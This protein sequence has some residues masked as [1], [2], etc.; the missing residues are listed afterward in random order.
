MTQGNHINHALAFVLHLVEDVQLLSFS[1]R[2][3]YGFARMPDWMRTLI[4]GQA[5]P[6][7][8]LNLFIH[9][10][11]RVQSPQRKTLRRTRLHHTVLL[12]VRAG[13]TYGDFDWSG[14]I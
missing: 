11:P 13:H 12:C 1:F 2:P 14:G 3:E 6:V 4:S 5:V 10:S 9:P 7:S 8:S